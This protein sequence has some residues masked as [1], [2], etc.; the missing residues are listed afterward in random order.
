MEYTVDVSKSRAGGAAAGFWVVL[1]GFLALIV[2]FVTGQWIIGVAGAVV[3]GAGMAFTFWR[4]FS[5][6][7]AAKR[8]EE[9]ARAYAA[10]QGLS[11]AAT[12]PGL[13]AQ[14]AVLDGHRPARAD[15]YS[16]IRG[17]EFGREVISLDRRGEIT[18]VEERS[19]GTYSRTVTISGDQGALLNAAALSGDR[20]PRVEIRER[21]ALDSDGV[22]LAERG[23]RVESAAFNDRWVVVAEDERAAHALLQPRVIDRLLQP[24]LDDVELC[25]A[26]GW[27]LTEQPADTRVPDYARHRRIVAEV[28]ALVPGFLADGSY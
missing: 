16:V 1:A 28:A 6:S 8:K 13:S 5:L 24:D 19:E 10:A 27:V 21:G 4:V 23:V 15:A 9:A 12:E 7:G 11:F 17:S 25:F 22:P 26:G 3:L 20:M 14:F 2:A 18:D